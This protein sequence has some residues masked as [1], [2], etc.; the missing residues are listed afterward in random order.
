MSASFTCSNL[1]NFYLKKIRGLRLLLIG[2]S[3]NNHKEIMRE[4]NYIKI[5]PKVSLRET[6]IILFEKKVKKNS[7]IGYWISSFRKYVIRIR[8]LVLKSGIRKLSDL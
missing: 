4:N 7:K 1:V 2:L 5:Q 6:I 8:Y 3:K